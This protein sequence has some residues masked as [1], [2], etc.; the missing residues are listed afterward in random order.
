VSVEPLAIASVVEDGA[1]ALRKLYAQG[2]SYQDFPIYEEEFRWIEKRLAAKK[3]LNRRTFRQRF[4]E[5][6]WLG[7]PKDGIEDLAAELKEERAFEEATAILGTMSEQLEK[8]NAIE[9]LTQMRG[10]ID[11]VTRHFAPMSD[12]DLDDWQDTIAEMKAGMLLAKT[13]QKPG[14][15]SGF[16]HIDHHI[17]GWMPG[18]L[19]QIL[20]RTGEG[21]SMKLAMFGW[22]GKKHNFNVGLFSPEM[23][24]HEVRCRY[25]TLASADK[26]VQAAL[27]LERSFRNRALYFRRGF[28][29]KSYERFVRYLKEH[30]KFGSFHLLSGMHRP[31]QM[32]VGYIEDRLVELELDLVLIDPIYLLKPVRLSGSGNEYQEVAWTAEAVH[33]LSEK[34]SIPIIFTNQAHMDKK[35]DAPHKSDSFGAKGQVHL[36]DWVLGVK[37]ISEERHMMVRTSKARHGNSFR[38]DMF[39]DANT[40]VWKEKTPLDGDYFNGHHDLADEDLATMME[41]AIGGTA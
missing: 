22:V 34:Y 19:I 17:G 35:D 29:I 26:D 27:G 16:K 36:A 28:N 6:E 9:L 11:G 13:G 12:V 8:D 30:D 20:G 14:I 41:S 31:E 39:F 25:H 3:P 18:Q 24:K 10:K 5:F 7:V 4:P 21:K 40:G 1:A 32:T 38:Y 2:I 33:N 15:P 23:S 37:H